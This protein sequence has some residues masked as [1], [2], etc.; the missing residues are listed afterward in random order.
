MTPIPT[1]H[2]EQVAVVTWLT[3]RRAVFFAVP[4]GGRVRPSQARK[5]KSEGMTAGAP[6]LVLAPR[7][8]PPIALEM[9]RSKGGRTSEAQEQMHDALTLRGW[10]VI[11]A[12]GALDAIEQLKGVDL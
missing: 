6:D 1:E 10:R 9:K 4:N 3:H 12:K 11:V 2:A 5:L 7:N 8:G